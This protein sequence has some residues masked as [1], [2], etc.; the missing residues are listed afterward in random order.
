MA[1]RAQ[2]LRVALRHI[3]RRRER[4]KTEMALPEPDSTKL[5]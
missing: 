4:R 5:V 1:A 3:D 2:V